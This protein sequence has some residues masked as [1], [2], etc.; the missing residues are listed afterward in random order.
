MRLTEEEKETAAS[1][2]EQLTTQRSSP[3]ATLV[4]FIDPRIAY[5]IGQ[6]AFGFPGFAQQFSEHVE[7]PPGGKHVAHLTRDLG[8]PAE[9]GTLVRS[10]RI[11]FQQH[12]ACIAR[13]A[14]EEHEQAPAEFGASF[15]RDDHGVDKNCSIRVELD[16]L[17]ATVG[18]DVLVLFADRLL[19]FLDLDAACLPGEAL[20]ADD[21]TLHRVKRVQQSHRK[22]AGGSQTGTRRQVGHGNHFDSPAHPGREE[23]FAHDRMLDLLDD[24]D[25]FGARVADPEVRLEMFLHGDVHMFVDGR[26]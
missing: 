8:H 1:G 21:F 18:G 14:G 19:E 12:L 17:Q 2:A 23:A 4:Q 6:R 13:V 11:L 10:R 5:R 3:Q 9:H 16:E 15:R 7:I 26:G 22:A 25:D 24:I 20:A